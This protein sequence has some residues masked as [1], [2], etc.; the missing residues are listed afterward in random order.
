MNEQ[1]NNYLKIYV[2]GFKITQVGSGVRE[3]R[4]KID[5]G[6]GQGLFP[7]VGSWGFNWVWVKM[8]KIKGQG[9]WVIGLGQKQG[10]YPTGGG[11][12]VEKQKL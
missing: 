3:I 10:F 2:L 1:N 8:D 9:V 12:G 6:R 11:G 4:V 5:E 7:W